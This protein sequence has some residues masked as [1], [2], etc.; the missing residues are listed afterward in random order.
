MRTA[1]R[2]LKTQ[3]ISMFAVLIL[4]SSGFLAA[5]TGREASRDAREERG[6]LLTNRVQ[7]L[8]RALDQS[9]W[10]W[11]KEMETLRTSVEL[12]E[13]D[14]AKISLAINELQK[15]VPA[16]SWIGLMNPQGMVVASTGGILAGRD[17][18][19]CR[20]FRQGK[21]GLF[22][23]DV[24]KATLLAQLLPHP[25]HGPLKFVDVSMPISVGR[26][27]DWVLVGHLNWAWA[28]EL[29]KF[30]LSGEGSDTNTEAFILDA[31]GKMILSS[32]N[33]A[34]P[35]DIA[36]LRKLEDSPSAWAVEKWPDGKSYL[37]AAVLCSG[38]KDYKGLRWSVVARQSLDAAYAPVSTL[39]WRILATGLALAA[40]FALFAVHIARRAMAPLNE[41]TET[42]DKLIRG[43]STAIPHNQG[44]REIEVLSAS[45]SALVDSL[46]R[47][48]R[49]KDRIQHEAER[50]TLTGLLNRHG[51]ATR[52]AEALPRLQQIHGSVEL[53]YM[54]LDGFKPINDTHGH[55]VGDA[56]LT[57]LGRRLTGCLRKEDVLVRLGGDEFLALQG[58]ETGAPD[59][60]QTIARIRRTAGMPITI[61]GL[62]LRVA[63]SIGHAT[64]HCTEESVDD[65]LKRADAALY[66][67]KKEAKNLEG[68]A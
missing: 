60:A 22:V 40:L 28:S 19:R 29:E 48:Q 2:S 68:P 16:F 63:I 55:H 41:L 50:D 25:E 42:A 37:T 62:M 32:G 65:A 33:A 53:F 36:L 12:L 35:L 20:I 31:N 27:M 59:V 17:L 39:V 45:L 44:I 67:D 8:S 10:F 18:S 66:R 54:D 52:I 1:A 3:F 9:M 56:V 4:I 49:D 15:I 61:D 13:T 34:E 14:M 38:F 21:G 43:E 47:S 64:W 11:I 23:G 58:H 57:I 46:T 7:T 30:I 26:L 51:L 6:R 24:R 5:I